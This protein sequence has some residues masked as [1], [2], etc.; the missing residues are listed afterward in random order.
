MAKLLV[1]TNDKVKNKSIYL[2]FTQWDYYSI[3]L[4]YVTC[5]LEDE[6][7][8]Q[9]FDVVIENWKLQLYKILLE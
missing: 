7:L 6:S 1:I 5:Y 3:F 2:F 4:Q 9:P 8:V